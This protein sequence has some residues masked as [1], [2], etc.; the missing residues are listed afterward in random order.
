MLN[1]EKQKNQNFLLRRWI[2]IVYFSKGDVI[3][4]LYINQLYG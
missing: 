2:F 1:N 4:S 3:E